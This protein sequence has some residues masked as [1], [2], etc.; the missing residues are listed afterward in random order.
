MAMDTFLKIWAVVGPL[1]VATVSTLWLRKTQLQDRAHEVDQRNLARKEALEDEERAFLRNATETEKR[2]LRTT[3]SEFI[4]C[5][6]EF[7]DAHLDL[8]LE[9]PPS[10]TQ[11][12][13]AATREQFNRVSHQLV[14]MA[15]GDL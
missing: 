13:C 4:H 15:P 9:H 12:R 2:E 5:T 10:N 7:V 11:E 6:G 14:L 8:L 1:I 3:A